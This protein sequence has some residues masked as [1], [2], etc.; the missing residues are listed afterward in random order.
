M[1]DTTDLVAGDSGARKSEATDRLREAGEAGD[2]TAIRALVNAGAD[3]NGTVEGGATF[4]AKVAADGRLDLVQALAAAGADSSAQS[5]NPRPDRDHKDA[6]TPLLIAM[7]R[8]HREVTAYLQGLSDRKVRIAARKRFAAVR[9][10]R[11]K[12]D[13]WF[14]PFLTAVEAGDLK[15]VADA[16][17]AGVDVN[18][19][20]EFYGNTA[21]VTASR[22]GH[23]EIVQRL[24][25]AG[26]DPNMMYAASSGSAPIVAALLAAG[27]KVNVRDTDGDTALSLAVAKGHSGVVEILKHAGARDA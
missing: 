5:P 2:A 16:I 7:I 26:A 1:S 4:L 15:T 22:C 8:G 19:G 17:E 23:T 20:D 18:A 10:K 21:L 14:K 6:V 25:A 9:R 24:L 12:R 11:G 13:P 3:P 27:A